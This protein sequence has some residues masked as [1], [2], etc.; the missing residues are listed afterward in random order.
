ME[1]IVRAEFPDF[2]AT[3]SFW[4][5]NV[6]ASDSQFARQSGM[7]SECLVSLKRLALLFGVDEDLLKAGFSHVR[8]I[9]MHL[10]Q[11]EKLDNMAAWRSALDQCRGKQVG[12]AELKCVLIRYCGWALS[13]S[14]C[15]RVFSKAERRI[16]AHRHLLDNQL[17]SDE[18]MLADADWVTPGEEAA[19]IKYAQT[20]WATMYGNCRTMSRAARVDR[21]V[22]KPHREGTEKS[23]IRARRRHV[24]D[25]LL[26]DDTDPTAGPSALAPSVWTDAHDKEPTPPLV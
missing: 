16:G 25:L 4:V 2:E 1:G 8:P 18:L 12:L 11:T 26:S 13:T 9:A 15:E 3:R 17:A 5:F 23:F 19:M 7:P 10:A 20:A 14:G 24:S 6:A 21:G 22:S